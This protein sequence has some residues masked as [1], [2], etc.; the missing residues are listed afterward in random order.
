MPQ[1]RLQANPDPRK[2]T[3]NA[4]VLGGVVSP[5]GLSVTQGIEQSQ[6]RERALPSTGYQQYSLKRGYEKEK[7]SKYENPASESSGNPGEKGQVPVETYKW[8]REK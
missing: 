6:L 2:R 4:E 8:L 1:G 3:V 7:K 5:G